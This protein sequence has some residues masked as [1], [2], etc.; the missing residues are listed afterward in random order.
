MRPLLLSAALVLGCGAAL[1]PARGADRKPAPVR[2]ER[3]VQPIL[4]RCVQC[5][6]PSKARAGLRLDSR[7]TALD[8]L[9]SGKHAVVPGKPDQSELLRRV[10]S[11][12][13]KKRMPRKG[14]PLTAAQVETLRRWIAAGPTGPNTGRIVRSPSRRRPLPSSPTGPARR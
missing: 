7:A 14:L 12:D 4:A 13:T 10:T 3:D 5:H 8:T 2:F 6:G 11:T 1:L 9:D